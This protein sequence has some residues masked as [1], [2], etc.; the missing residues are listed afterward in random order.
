MPRKAL[1]PF[2]AI[3]ILVSSPLA[4]AQNQDQS[5][6]NKWASSLA[7][8]PPMGWNTWNKMGATSASN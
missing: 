4:P 7:P 5:S 2:A 6:P 1:I 8:T 3:L